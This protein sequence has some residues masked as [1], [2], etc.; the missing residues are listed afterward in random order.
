MRVKTRTLFH[1]EAKTCRN[2]QRR[3][4]YILYIYFGHEHLNFPA[5][6]FSLKTFRK[7]LE[8]NIHQ[9]CAFDDLPFPMKNKIQKKLSH[10]FDSQC[11]FCDSVFVKIK[12]QN[13]KL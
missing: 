10:I 12:G 3:T 4:S 9:I 2:W 1:G 7:N 8:T 11:V 6:R 13:C 5:A